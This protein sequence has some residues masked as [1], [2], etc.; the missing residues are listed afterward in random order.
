MPSCDPSNRGCGTVFKLT[1]NDDQSAWKDDDQS[2]WKETI[3]Y[4]FNPQNGSDG[5]VPSPGSLITDNKGALYGT[6]ISGGN[7]GV[8]LIPPGYGTVF[9]LT[10]QKN[11][12]FNETVIYS[13]N[14]HSDGAYPYAGLTIDNGEFYGTTAGGG[15]AVGSSGYGTVFKLTPSV[16]GKTWM[17]SV[18]Y[19]FCSKTG[20]SDGANPY[21]F[22]GLTV[23]KSGAIYGTTYIGGV[24]TGGTIFKLT[25]LNSVW[26]ETVL[27]GFQGS[28]G[29]NP[30]ASLTPYNGALYGVTT[31]GGTAGFGTVFKLQG[32]DDSPVEVK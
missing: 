24:G 3:L 12:T 15:S 17:E 9:K 27:Y 23:D 25:N 31:Q 8:A 28:D 10:P 16:N 19:A 30:F 18:V 29:T 7:A 2:A 11:E 4:R 22:A 1:P 26:T 14:G 32:F 20:C 5:I 21:D 6:T 13:F